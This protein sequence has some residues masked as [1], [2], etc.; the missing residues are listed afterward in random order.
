MSEI[1][2]RILFQQGC[3]VVTD[4]GIECTFTSYHI[5]KDRL[6]ETDWVEHVGEKTWVVKSDFEAV[7]KKALEIHGNLPP[8]PEL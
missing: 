5:S 3:W 4:F 6:H 8:T 1:T 7:Y 2:G